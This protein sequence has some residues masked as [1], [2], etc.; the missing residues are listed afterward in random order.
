MRGK[1]NLTEWGSEN[2]NRDKINKR[3]DRRIQM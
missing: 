2:A 1:I 3:I